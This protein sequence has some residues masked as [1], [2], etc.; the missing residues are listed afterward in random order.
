MAEDRLQRIAVH[1]GGNIDLD[2][3]DLNCAANMVP[4]ESRLK[5]LCEEVRDL[6]VQLSDLTL[7]NDDLREQLLNLEEA[8]EEDE[9]EE[10][11]IDEDLATL[12]RMRERR[13]ESWCWCR[14]LL[15]QDVSQLSH[16]GW[17]SAADSSLVAK[18]RA[19]RF[20][21]APW[22]MVPILRATRGWATGGG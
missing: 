8:E 15:T 2:L 14:R 5:A 12:G 22:I 1:Y 21:S 18:P 16:V 10:Q 11:S 19:G 9:E 13:S 7:E 3:L 4:M 17:R 6:R 20:R